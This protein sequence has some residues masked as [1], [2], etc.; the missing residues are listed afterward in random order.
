MNILS[1]A[2]VGEAVL[3]IKRL[4]QLRPHDNVE[5]ITQLAKAL[6]QITVPM[7]RASIFWLVGQ[8]AQ[9][10]ELVAPDILRKAAKDFS[11]SDDVVKLQVIT[12][13]VKLICLHPTDHTLGLL[14]E[15]IMNLARY[16]VNYDIRDRARML[17]GLR[18]EQ[19][20]EEKDGDEK[21]V[22]VL[23]EKMKAILLGDK[24][25]P[26]ESLSMGMF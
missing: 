18:N 21:N 17:K 16:D 15:Y 4:L 10:L 5:M 25:A 26:V 9:K 19:R 12:L 23:N 7:A 14:Y 8:Y 2:I 13:A 1:D 11:N 6:D 3:V 24:E 20:L 22:E